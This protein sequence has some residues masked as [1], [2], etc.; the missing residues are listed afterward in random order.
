LHAKKKAQWKNRVIVGAGQESSTTN[1][2]ESAADKNPKV[3]QVGD[4]LLG[5]EPFFPGLQPSELEQKVA[6]LLL[7]LRENGYRVSYELWPDRSALVWRLRPGDKPP[8]Q[9]PCQEWN[10]LPFSRDI[11]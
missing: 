4:S 1:N 2:E 5:R 7:Y 3:R 6:A 9:K 10:Y 11:V 8:P